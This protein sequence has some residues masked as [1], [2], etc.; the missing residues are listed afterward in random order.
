NYG[1]SSSNIT[2]SERVSEKQ[3][4]SGYHIGII[5][6][7]RIT[8]DVTAWASVSAGNRVTGYELGIGYDVAQNTELNLFYRHTKYQDF[9]VLDADVDVTTKGLGVGVTVK[10]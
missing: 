7:T 3:S 4:K 8:D 10:F 2:R 5:G 9:N 6:Q 1:S